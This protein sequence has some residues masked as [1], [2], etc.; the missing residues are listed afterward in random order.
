MISTIAIGFVAVG[1]LMGGKIITYGKRRAI[2]I[3]DFLAIVASVMSAFLDWNLML[4]GRALY[5]F[6]VGVIVTATPKIIDETIPAHLIDKGFGTSTNMII[7]ISIMYCMILGL[8]NPTDTKE[9]ETTDFWR[10]FYL[11]PIPINIIAML[12]HFCDHK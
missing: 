3:F 8:G 2:L 11:S 6:C 5:S 7:N 9:L 1:S 12:W 10:Y 4:A